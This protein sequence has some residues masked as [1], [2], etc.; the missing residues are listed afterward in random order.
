ME[1][2]RKLVK[3]PPGP[4]PGV[5][6]VVWGAMRPE[7][8]RLGIEEREGSEEVKGSARGGGVKSRCH[9]CLHDALRGKVVLGIG[10]VHCADHKAA[11]SSERCCKW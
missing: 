7:V 11:V 10:E 9:R 6:V 4:S 8:H 5:Q 3:D 1:A 2:G